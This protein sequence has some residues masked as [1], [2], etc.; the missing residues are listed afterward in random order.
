MAGIKRNEL[1]LQDAHER[2]KTVTRSE[3]MKE[4]REKMQ[5]DI[6]EVNKTAHQVKQRL[7]R[8]DKMNQQALSRPVSTCNQKICHRLQSINMGLWLLDLLRTHDASI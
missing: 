4:I 2:S 8:L 5:D 1:A 7:E 3:E 6:D